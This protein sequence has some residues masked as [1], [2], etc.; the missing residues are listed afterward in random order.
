M[1]DG[2]YPYEIVSHWRVPGRIEAVYAVLTDAPALPRWWP[3]AYGKVLE[4]APGDP[5]TGVGRTSAVVTRGLLPY[6]I[7]WRITL[8]EARR[9]D[10]IRIAAH[11]DVEGVGE[12]RLRQEDAAVALDYD[13]RVRVG[14]P[15][16][17]RFERLLKPAFVWNHN[18]VMRRGERGLKAELARRAAQI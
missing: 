3:E 7:H 11:G 4:I 14:K 6:A 5:A 12:W 2:A 8:V 17:R 18:F 16:M 9:P 15:W 1:T 13:W 10:F